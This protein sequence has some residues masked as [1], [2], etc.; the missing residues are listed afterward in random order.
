MADTQKMGAASFVKWEL[1]DEWC[2]RWAKEYFGDRADAVAE[3]DED[4]FD[5]R[6]LGLEEKDKVAFSE[7]FYQYDKDGDY[8]PEEEFETGNRYATLP[9]S[10]SICVLSKFADELGMKKIGHAVAIYSGVYFMENEREYT[11]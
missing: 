5:I 3:R 9:S 11:M 1:V 2:S 6:I 8:D 7:L 10:I 4:D